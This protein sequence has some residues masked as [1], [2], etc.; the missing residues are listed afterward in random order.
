VVEGL[1]KGD[2]NRE[3]TKHIES[4]EL[5]RPVVEGVNKG[6]LPRKPLKN[7]GEYNNIK[8]ELSSTKTVY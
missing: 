3:G 7:R 1:S 2:G 8:G 6:G 5:H 4:L